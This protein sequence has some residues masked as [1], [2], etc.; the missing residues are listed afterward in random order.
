M[1]ARQ[2]IETDTDLTGLVSRFASHDPAQVMAVHFRWLGQTQTCVGEVRFGEQSQG[3]PGF[4]H[5]GALAAI[6]DEA[7]GIA[8]WMSGYCAPGA[9]ITS[10][11]IKPARLGDVCEVRAWLKSVNGRKLQCAASIKRGEVEVYRAAGL[12][13]AIEPTDLQM[14]SGWPGVERFLPPAGLASRRVLP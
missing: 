6:A 3:L 1:I 14:F 12:F 9:Q 4:V 7:M 10:D 11:F 2:A 5:G 13:I 8:C